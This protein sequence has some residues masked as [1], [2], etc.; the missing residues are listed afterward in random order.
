[1]DLM[2]GG[3][4]VEPESTC[5]TPLPFISRHLTKWEGRTYLGN[6]DII[7]MELVNESS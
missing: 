6:N 1:M 2:V 3:S 5:I 7:R 4:Y